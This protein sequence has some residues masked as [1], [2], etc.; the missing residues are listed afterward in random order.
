MASPSKTQFFF[1]V[2]PPF[3]TGGGSRFEVMEKG[4]E[5]S[6]FQ[7][8]KKGQ[9]GMVVALENTNSLLL[10]LLLQSP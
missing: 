1:F 3:R 5:I 6:K 4:R 2:F 9:V 7:S 8:P 10:L